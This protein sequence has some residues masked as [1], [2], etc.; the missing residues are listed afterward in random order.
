MALV[1]FVI[2]VVLV[3]YVIR[4]GRLTN[5]YRSSKPDSRSQMTPAERLERRS[6]EWNELV[7]QIKKNQ[8]KIDRGEEIVDL[9]N[10][11][12]RLYAQE[13][14]KI[15]K[16]SPENDPRRQEMVRNLQAIIERNA[17]INDEKM[18]RF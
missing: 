8:R 9:E 17:M 11:V 18:N 10:P 16:S 1:L 4:N 13:I 12:T 5:L 2:I 7:Y 14:D 3:C 15:V 6:R